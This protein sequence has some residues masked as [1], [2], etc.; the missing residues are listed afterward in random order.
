MSMIRISLLQDFLQF[1]FDSNPE[2]RKQEK[3]FL[4]NALCLKQIDY[5]N[6]FRD[7]ASDCDLYV[8]LS[9]FQSIDDIRELFVPDVHTRGKYVEFFKEPPVHY[10]F[11]RQGTTPIEDLITAKLQN[12]SKNSQS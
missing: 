11:Q 6:S 10:Q 7:T 12:Q 4:E 8:H 1:T 5:S 3:Q 9:Q 2:K